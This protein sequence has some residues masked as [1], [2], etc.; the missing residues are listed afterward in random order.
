M[1]GS[2][3]VAEQIFDQQGVKTVIGGGP[4]RTVGPGEC[5]DPGEQILMRG[6]EPAF[7]V[8]L[9]HEVHSDDDIPEE[10]GLALRRVAERLYHVTTDGREAPDDDGG[11]VEWIVGPSVHEGG[12]VLFL[13]TDGDG[14]SRPMIE[15]MGRIFV[16]ELTPLA[17]QAHISGS[18]AFPSDL[19]PDWAS[20]AERNGG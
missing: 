20:E 15:T 13:D 3:T 5:P 11:H 1:A 10:L 4:S 18:S 14:F 9:D 8:Q 19:G 2:V 6:G 12:I 16:D 7:R 17:L